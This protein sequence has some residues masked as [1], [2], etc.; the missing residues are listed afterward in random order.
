MDKILS[1]D[2]ECANTYAYRSICHIGAV[3]ADCDFNVIKKH[4]ILVNPR[5][6]SFHTGTV[7]L[8]YTIA[9]LKQYPDFEQRSAQLFSLMSPDTLV[10]GHSLH[11]DIAMLE[12]ACRY[13]SLKLPSFKYIDSNVVIS[14]IKGE[15]KESSLSAAALE[16][17]MDFD[18]MNLQ[19][20]NPCDDAYVTLQVTKM[21]L[22]KENLSLSDFMKKHGI[23]YGYVNNGLIIRPISA[24]MSERT[25]YKNKKTNE[26]YAY[27]LENNM[28]CVKKVSIDKNLIFSYDLKPLADKLY[29]KGIGIC[30]DRKN[31][32]AYITTSKKT[33]KCWNFD[34]CLRDIFE[35]KNAGKIKRAIKDI[36]CPAKPA[37]E[38]EVGDNAATKKTS[39]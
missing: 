39:D 25:L 13:Y 1:L 23:E 38:G 31:A 17:G 32:F 11:N 16:Y 19:E 24:Y 27:L 36:N 30:D 37:A 21:A 14:A 10:L 5:V 35:T 9:E 33:D 15:S 3:E 20:H 4:D 34:D 6:H 28:Q 7:K 26:L 29:A 8:P 22:M 18:L 12:S 2:L